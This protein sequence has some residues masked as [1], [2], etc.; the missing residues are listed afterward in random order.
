MHVLLL[1]AHM[2]V[3]GDTW[4]LMIAGIRGSTLPLLIAAT[5]RILSFVSVR[6]SWQKTVL[7]TLVPTSRTVRKWIFQNL[8]D[9]ASKALSHLEHF[10]IC[11]SRF[12]EYWISFVQ[13]CTD[14]NLKNLTRTTPS[15]WF[16]LKLRN[17][18]LCR[19]Y[20]SVSCRKRG[21]FVFPSDCC[22]HRH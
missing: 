9:L 16:L 3:I 1:L 6:R 4:P 2:F 20:C 12:V 22:N 19:A 17:D 13:P 7:S 11:I 21:C 15:S 18:G 10:C 14:T 5:R 8:L